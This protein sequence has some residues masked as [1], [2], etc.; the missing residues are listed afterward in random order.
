MQKIFAGRRMLP[1]AVKGDIYNQK[2]GSDVTYG[3]VL[4]GVLSVCCGCDC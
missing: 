4:T 2:P 1:L 3:C